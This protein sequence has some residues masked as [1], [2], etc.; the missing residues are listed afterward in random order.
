MLALKILI[1][2]HQGYLMQGMD[3]KPGSCII[4]FLDIFQMCASVVTP[5]MVEMAKVKLA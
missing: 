1:V 5:P 3:L 2:K 4:A